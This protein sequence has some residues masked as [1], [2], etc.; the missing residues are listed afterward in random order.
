MKKQT[1]K[2]Y[3]E[4]F[5]NSVYYI[6]KNIDTN[7][8]LEE[9]AYENNISKY[10]FH[11]IFK[12]EAND[13]L[14]NFISSIRLQKAANLLISNENSSI[15]DIYRQ[16]GYSSHS[17]F[18]K[19]FKEKFNFT[20]KDWRK[21]KYL[22]HT[23]KILKDIN[24]KDINAQ[25]DIVTKPN[26]RCAY[27]RHKGYNE[28]LKETWQ[29]IRAVKTKYDLNKNN[30]IGLYHDNP[31]IVEKEKC[32]YVAAI[33]IDE[34]QIIE[35]L[36]S[37][38]IPKSLCVNFIYE[39]EYGDILNAIRYIYQ[40]WLKDSPYEAT[41]L[42]SYVIYYKNHLIKKDDFKVEINIPIKIK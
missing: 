21:G 6:Y 1:I 9:L 40:E 38:T 30:E 33:Q 24:I 23:K 15:S 37:F 10:H 36:S 4:I 42:P 34:N 17:S 27:I 8:T 28:K 20:P 11:R 32:H 29:F 26:I 19:S 22:E 18:T 39:G 3:K 16:C 12:N 35:E 13:T 7:I 5:N 2:N 31:S 25:I 14:N 41:T